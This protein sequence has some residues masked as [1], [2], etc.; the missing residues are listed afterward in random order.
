MKRE[1]AGIPVPALSIPHQLGLPVEMLVVLLTS[2]LWVINGRRS[3]QFFLK[4]LLKGT[5][6]MAR[7]ETI[8]PPTKK[9]TSAASAL[10]RA[11][12]SAGARVMADKSVAV[13][14]AKAGTS[15]GK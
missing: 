3:R 14:Q 12:N 5:R 1:R 13:R 2:F 8:K 10:L 6:K 7:K 15:K 4:R 9:E 11:G